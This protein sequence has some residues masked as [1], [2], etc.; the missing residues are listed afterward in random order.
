MNKIAQ[1]FIERAGLYLYSRKNAIAFVMACRK[2][3]VRL[4]GIDGFI[5][6]SNSTQPSMNNS[7]DFSSSFFKG[8][9]YDEAIVF[10]E[11]QPDELFF[12]IVFE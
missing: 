12:E 8:D 2:E 9:V 11:I 1:I 4:L 7:I 6:T 5:I 10:L 3:K